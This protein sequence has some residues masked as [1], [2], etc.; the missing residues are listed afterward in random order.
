MRLLALD[1]ATLVASA[2]VWIDGAVVVDGEAAAS[3]HSEKLLPL[4]DQVLRRAGLVPADLDAVACGAGP[5]S[6]T[7]LRIGLATAKGLCFALG[8]P[9]VLCSSLAA[10]ALEGGRGTVLAVLDAKRQEVYAGLYRLDPLPAP[11]DDEVV[12][13]P[14]DV[15]AWAAG[16]ADAVVG[17]G[18]YAYPDDAAA[19]GPLVATARRTPSAAA[20]ARLAAAR[21]ARGEADDLTRAEPT[22]IRHDVATPPRAR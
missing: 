18:A 20:V 22:Y 4:A 17:D 5:G 16:R 12:L 1:T 9:L 8:R 7:G 14:G 6:F 19:W 11:V 10:L 13:A 21:L 15:A 3:T 2:A